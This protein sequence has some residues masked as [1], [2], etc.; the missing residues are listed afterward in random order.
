MM[1]VYGFLEGDT[2]GILL[3]AYA[4]ETVG[5]LANKLQLSSKFR[6]PVMKKPA[7]IFKGAELDQNLLISSTSIQALDRVD[8]IETFK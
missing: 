3:F 8:V 5:S 4:D 1:P 7:L 6:V 2:L